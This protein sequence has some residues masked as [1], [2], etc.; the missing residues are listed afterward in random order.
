MLTYALSAVDTN[1]YYSQLIIFDNV[2]LNSDTILNTFEIRA[3][4]S[5]SLYLPASSVMGI[6]TV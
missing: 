3:A 2:K 4:Q 5:Y 6:A 1:L